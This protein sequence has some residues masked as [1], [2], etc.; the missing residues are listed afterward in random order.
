MFVLIN[1]E[2]VS[3]NNQFHKKINSQ[4]IP[5][6]QSLN[7]SQKIETFNQNDNN[8]L[9]N[10]FLTKTIE[11]ENIEKKKRINSSSHR[12]HSLTINNFQ[13]KKNHVIFGNKNPFNTI[14]N[15]DM[16]NSS[17]YNS[18]VRTHLFSEPNLRKFLMKN[19]IDLIKGKLNHKKKHS[20]LLESSNISNSEIKKN[21]LIPFINM[22]NENNETHSYFSNSINQNKILKKM[23]T[24]HFYNNN[25]YSYPIKILSYDFNNNSS[26]LYSE[27]SKMPNLKSINENL[28]ENS[29]KERPKSSRIHESINK[30]NFKEIKLESIN[31]DN[32][33]ILYKIKSSS[34]I[35]LTKLTKRNIDDEYKENYQNNNNFHNNK[36]TKSLNE[37]RKIVSLNDLN[38]ISSQIKT[39]LNDSNS[40][41]KNTKT[42]Q[43]IQ[44]ENI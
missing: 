39:I 12:S 27:F 32:N 42:K 34:T 23:K 13:L 8:F 30:N 36:K 22:T 31:K 37:R 15:S 24:S 18:S 3:K 19:E 28:T 9:I 7:Y 1:R 10:N 14:E 17:T 35:K 43:S 6:I 29:F 16:S 4:N 26:Y 40:T 2:I 38:E 25:H 20:V 21:N 44:S 41:I 33:L 5:L 11:H